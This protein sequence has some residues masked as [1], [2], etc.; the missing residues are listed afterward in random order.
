MTQLSVLLQTHDFLTQRDLP[1]L[2]FKVDSLRWNAIG[3][4]ESATITVE[5]D[6]DA[7]EE[8]IDMTGDPVVVYDD[9]GKK[10]WWGQVFEATVQNDAVEYGETLEEMANR[11]AVAYDDGT[12]GRQTTAWAQ[13]VASMDRRGTIERLYTTS[14]RTA[15]QCTILR[16]TKLALVGHPLPILRDIPGGKGQKATLTCKG[17]YGTLNNQYYS[18]S[19][20]VQEYKPAVWGD[21]NGPIIILNDFYHW[22]YGDAKQPITFAGTVPWRLDTASF[23]FNM[24]GGA[25]ALNVTMT[26]GG[27]TATGSLAAGMHPWNQLVP[28]TMRT[29][30]G[31]RPLLSPGVVYTF[32]FHTVTTTQTWKIGYAALQ[33]TD[34]IQ[35]WNGIGSYWAI[36]NYTAMYRLSG[37]LDNVVQIATAVA[38]EGEFITAVDQVNLSGIETDPVRDA[39]QKLGDLVDDL[40]AAGTVN[41][42]RLLAEVTE[43]RRLR[44]HEEPIADVDTVDYLK[45]P[46]GTIED[47][48]GNSVS[49][50]TNIAGQWCIRKESLPPV[51]SVPATESALVFVES[52]EYS[53]SDDSLTLEPRTLPEMFSLFDLQE[54]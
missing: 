51:S 50:A 43:D 30:G 12:N 46:D 26:G 41:N 28:I 47:R 6:L 4:C 3:G 33:G 45:R 1:G 17:W 52:C 32:Q 27:V 7:L 5:G 37:F 25:P 9:T 22:E 40:L 21:P 24:E 34:R 15:A 10:V 35:Q 19:N 48:L 53:G 23:I 39:E 16:D 13:D 8:L 14:N 49:P 38:A 54:G 2:R 44:I 20:L 29:A 31:E 18:T 11:V 36:Y 42:L